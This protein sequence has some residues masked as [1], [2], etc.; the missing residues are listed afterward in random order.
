[1]HSSA[2]LREARQLHS[3]SDCHDSLA[4]TTSSRSEA[5]IT[6]SDNIRHTAAL[7]EAL[8]VMKMRL[9]SGA[10]SSRWLSIFYEMGL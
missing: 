8:V 7:L 9:F 5:L 10:R 1:M 3:V 2:I 4:G 6:S